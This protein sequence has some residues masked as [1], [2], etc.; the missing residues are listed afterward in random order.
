VL[1]VGNFWVRKKKSSEHINM[2]SIFEDL[3]ATSPTV[4]MDFQS[5]KWFGLQSFLNI[6]IL[7]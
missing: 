6:Q 2:G 7:H 3:I 1:G 5:D 4:K